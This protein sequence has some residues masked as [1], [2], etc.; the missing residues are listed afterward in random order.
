MAEAIGLVELNSP[1]IRKLNTICPDYLSNNAKILMK[2]DLSRILV[3]G[4]KARR[5]L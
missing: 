4:K 5:H 2:N 1:M 3:R